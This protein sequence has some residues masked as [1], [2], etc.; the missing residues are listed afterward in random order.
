MCPKSDKIQHIFVSVE[1]LTKQYHCLLEATEC[2]AFLSS[3]SSMY[4]SYSII[5]TTQLHIIIAFSLLCLS[6]KPRQRQKSAKPENL[7]L[8]KMQSYTLLKEVF[9]N[10]RRYC[11]CLVVDFNPVMYSE[12]LEFLA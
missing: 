3:L 7:Y 5:H 4:E 2:S 10:S 12:H 11:I 1:V 8:K 9:Q 6:C